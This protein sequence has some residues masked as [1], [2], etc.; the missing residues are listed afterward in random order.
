MK[1]V[2]RVD[3]TSR[4]SRKL[5]RITMTQLKPWGPICLLVVVLHE[6]L[7]L[8]SWRLATFGSAD[9][10]NTAKGNPLGPVR[11]K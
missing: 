10:Q 7:M 1:R 6:A 9:K 3:V 5:N 4:D 2:G 8:E 11:R